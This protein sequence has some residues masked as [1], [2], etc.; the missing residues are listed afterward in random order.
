VQ[1]QRLDSAAGESAAELRAGAG[2][3]LGQCTRLDRCSFRWR[4]AKDRCKLD[5]LI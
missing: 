4:K 5:P 3:G 1:R 2:E